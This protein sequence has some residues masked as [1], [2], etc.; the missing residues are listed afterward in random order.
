MRRRRPRTVITLL[1]MMPLDPD[2]ACGRGSP[3]HDPPVDTGQGAF[4]QI[5]EQCPSSPDVPTA[6]ADQRE[7]DGLVKTPAGW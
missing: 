6:A 3:T 4:P 7:E 5:Q 2:P 1:T